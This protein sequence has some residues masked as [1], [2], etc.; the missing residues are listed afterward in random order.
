M[1]YKIY[2][3]EDEKSLNDILSH[4]IR[5]QG[6][7]LESFFNGL[8]AQKMIENPPHLWILDIML[9]DID[10]IQLIKE[11]KLSTPDVPVIF[12]SARNSD[13]D[14]IMGLELGSDDYISKPFLPRELII[15]SQK[16]LDRVYGNNFEDKSIEVIDGYQVNRIKRF[17]SYEGRPIDLTSKEFDMLFLFIDKKGQALSR[18]YILNYIWGDNAFYTD[19]VV[20]NLVKRLRKKLPNIKIETIYAYGYRRL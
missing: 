10:G 5:K 6:W 7:L 14:R 1:S 17:V 11:I 16:L 12:M 9:P 15:R 13:M 2:L 8:D 18:E 20:D 3:V 4:Y 19:R